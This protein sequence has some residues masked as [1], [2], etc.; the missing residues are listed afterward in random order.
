MK[1]DTEKLKQKLI[2]TG[3]AEIEK[4]GIDQLSIRMVA[5]KCGVSHGAPYR[6]FGSKEGYL[7]VVLAEISLRL[8]KASL[9]G[10]SERLP[11][12][13][14]LSLMGANL[15]NFAKTSPYF[16]EV[17]LVKYPFSYLEILEDQ[18]ELDCDLP[19]FQAF[20]KLVKDFR[21]EEN[22]LVSENDCLFHLWSYIAGL[23]ILAQ[24]QNGQ[25]L[26]Q[27]NIQKNIDTMLTIYIKG[28][29]A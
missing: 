8:A 11:A 28:G 2:A 17:L 26:S 1:R 21:N 13:Q 29:K 20:Q 5:Q 15:I 7:K 22:L 12:R 25:D 18:V 10:L 6:H 23:A 4:K 14:Q 16:F 3:V 27:A 19:G 9:E 24:S